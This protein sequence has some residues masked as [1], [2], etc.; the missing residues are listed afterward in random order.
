MGKYVF[1]HPQIQMLLWSSWVCK[2]GLEISQFLSIS[3]CKDLSIGCKDPGLHRIQIRSTWD[4][5]CCFITTRTQGKA[6][7]KKHCGDQA[8]P[9]VPSRGSR[10]SAFSG[11]LIGPCSLFSPAGYPKKLSGQ[12]HR[13]LVYPDS[14]PHLAFWSLALTLASW[15]QPANYLWSL[16]LAWLRLLLI[17]PGCSEYPTLSLLTAALWLFLTCRRQ[18]NCDC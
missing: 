1:I 17:D 14:R 7:S 3:Q 13:F 5:W 12:L 10:V 8:P 6:T 2:T 16:T 15:F 4:C 11:P 18:S 9:E